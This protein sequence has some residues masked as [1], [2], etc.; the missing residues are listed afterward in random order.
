MPANFKFAVLLS[1]QENALKFSVKEM[2]S[3]LWIELLVTDFELLG[4][5]CDGMHMKMQ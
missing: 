4:M 3:V 1:C 5:K 2:L